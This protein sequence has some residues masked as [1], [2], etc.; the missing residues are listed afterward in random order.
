M[1]AVRLIKISQTYPDIFDWQYVVRIRKLL[2]S[3]EDGCSLEAG[4]M[5][6]VLPDWSL[7]VAVIKVNY[8]GKEYLE[9]F[10]KAIHRLNIVVRF[11]S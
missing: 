2:L 4:P 6:W 8:D 5:A 9:I 11:L 7:T 10:P 1:I 3:S